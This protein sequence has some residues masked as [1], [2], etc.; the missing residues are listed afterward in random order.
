MTIDEFF[1]ELAKLKDLRWYL[2]KNGAIRVELEC[3][4]CPVAAVAKSKF[5]VTMN[6]N[7][8][9]TMNGY[10]LGLSLHDCCKIADASDHANTFWAEERNRLMKALGL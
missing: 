5:E 2:N 7:L 4:Y 10:K 3:E 1:T 6:D 8:N 9:F